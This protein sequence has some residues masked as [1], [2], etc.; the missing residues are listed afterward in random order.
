MQKSAV[1]ASSDCLISAEGEGNVGDAAA[2]FAARADMLD[3][4]GGPNEVH[5]I[6]VMLRHPRANSQD[7]GVEHN[8][9]WI[10]ANLFYQDAICP[11]ANPNL[12]IN[13]LHPKV[14][15]TTQIFSLHSKTLHTHTVG[16]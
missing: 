15:N 4:P 1:E 14:A 7:I 3:D 13:L 6:V 10:E 9:L 2:D 16:S 8:I 5:R 12:H 11:L